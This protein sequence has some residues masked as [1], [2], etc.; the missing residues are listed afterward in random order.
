MTDQFKFDNPIIPGS[1]W[2]KKSDFTVPVV[3]PV[4]AGPKGAKGDKLLFSDLTE[5]DIDHIRQGIA[6]SVNVSQDA[7]YTTTALTTQITI[8]IQDFDADFDMLFVDVNGLDLSEHGDYEI[9]GNKIVLTTAIPAGQDV[10]FRVLKYLIPDGDKTINITD[11]RKDYNTVA[12]MQADTTLQ[13]GDICHT[14]GYYAAGDGGAAWYK[15]VSHAVANG[16]DIINVGTAYKA[17]II[18]QNELNIVCFAGGVTVTDGYDDWIIPI[19]R[20]VEIASGKAIIVIPEGTF[21]ISGTITMRANTT[22]KGIS[23]ETSIIQLIPYKNVNMFMIGVAGERCSSTLD[24]LCLIGDFKQSYD[25]VHETRSEYGN[26]VV[27][28]KDTMDGDGCKIT[29]CYIRNFAENGIVVNSNIYV[30]HIE[31]CQIMFNRRNGIYNNG[32]DNFFTN[33]RIYYNGLSGIK[34]YMCGANKF[35]NIKIYYNCRIEG[36]GNDDLDATNPSYNAGLMERS[37]S[38][39]EYH[40]IELQDNYRTGASFYTVDGVIF[41]GSFD[42]NGFI[43][44]SEQAANNELRLAG[45]TNMDMR[46]IFGR[47]DLGYV[48]HLIYAFNCAN[49]VIS[50]SR[51]M[52]AQADDPNVSGTLVYIIGTSTKLN[53]YPAYNVVAGEKITQNVSFTFNNQN[54]I[55]VN[56]SIELGSLQSANI[57]AFIN[58]Y[59]ANPVDAWVTISGTTAYLHARRVLGDTPVTE[60]VTGRLTILVI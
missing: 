38:R 2:D 50:Y 29:N 18:I 35:N 15:I 14:L 60:T 41:D 6:N 46:P 32:T 12:E 36:Q 9:V 28:K 7:V 17:H 11:N 49:S 39:N 40:G 10:H 55:A 13:P 21:Y 23:Q 24:S 27:F 53:I 56:Q 30:I 54:E 5:N 51:A 25:N 34:N 22:I 47:N 37:C 1:I 59:T 48:A 26:G 57:V 44:S 52:E 43:G 19:R 33:L 42:D 4:G 20:A 8:P 58:L 31:N 16:M 3:S 45:C